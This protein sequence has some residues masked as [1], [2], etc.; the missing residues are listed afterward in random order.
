VILRQILEGYKRI[1]DKHIVHRD[2]KPDNILF[3]AAPTLNKQIA[4]IDFGYCE[5]REV[6]N[7][8]NMFY[9]VGSPKYMAPEAFKQNKYS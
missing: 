2:L 3:K 6:P 9:N 8:P 7:K 4:I 5:M 1:K